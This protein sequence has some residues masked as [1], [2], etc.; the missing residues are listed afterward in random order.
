M[1][2][3]DIALK[4]YFSNHTRLADI[5]NYYCF[6]GRERIAPSGLEIQN[7]TEAVVLGDSLDNPYPVEKARDILAVAKANG[8]VLLLLGIENQNNIHYGMPVRQMLYDA[9]TYANQIDNR[10]KDH[11]NLQWNKRENVSNSEFLSGLKKGEK[12]TPVITLLIYYGKEPWDGPTNLSHMLDMEQVP[13]E[14]RPYIQSHYALNLLEARKIQDYENFHS[15]IRE[16]FTLLSCEN[17]K[18]KMKE[19]MENNK[20]YLNLDRDAVAAIG[21]LTASKEIMNYINQEQK[22]GVDMCQAIREMIEDGR[23]EGRREGIYGCIHVL[24]KMSCSDNTIISCII[25]QFNL[26]TE[27]AKTY[28]EQV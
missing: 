1:G 4:K 5:F 8:T 13:E 26:S 20:N 9:L 11:R 15:D 12:L 2:L 18:D 23:Q 3:P 21:A 28:I 10:K 16:V 17:D 24:R 6:N 25:D 22:G 7:N 14:F 27:E 19:I